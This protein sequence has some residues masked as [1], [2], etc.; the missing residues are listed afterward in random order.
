MRAGAGFVR[1]TEGREEGR[2]EDEEASERTNTEN[3]P[4]RS[5]LRESGGG[6]DEVTKYCEEEY[7]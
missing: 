1:N 4:L 2:E 6:T 3:I 5:V 7:V